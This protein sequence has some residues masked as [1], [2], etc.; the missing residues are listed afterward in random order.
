MTKTNRT[1]IASVQAQNFRRLTFA[2]VKLIPSTGLV[3]VT[4]NN[5][6]GKTSFLK[7]I[8]GGLGGDAEVDAGSL[9]EGTKKGGFILRTHDGRTIEKRI[10]EANPKGALTV[11]APDG[12]KHGQAK[13]NSWL[14][15]K[16]FDPMALFTLKADRL[17]DVLFSVGTDP[18][19]PTKLQKVREEHA[20]VY[21]E[22]TPIISRRRHLAT[23]TE[24]VG[25]R[26]ESVDTSA[27]MARLTALQAEEHAREEASRA[28]SIAHQE[29]ATA[30]GTVADSLKEIERIESLLHGAHAAL[31]ADQG[32]AKV[33]V[34]RAK[35]AKDNAN[36][37]RDPTEDMRV[38]QER[39][40]A[41][42]EIQAAIQPWSRWDEARQELEKLAED[43]DHLKGRLGQ[44]KQRE[45]D[46]LENAGIPVDGLSFGD[47]GEPLL[48]GKSL[49]LASGREKVDMAVAVAF[50][51]DPE[52]RVCLLDEE[53][54]GLDLEA[55]AHLHQR[56]IKEEFQIWLCRVG[57]ES[58][59][60]IIVEDGVA[61]DLSPELNV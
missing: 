55:M 9:H 51:A 16:S 11:T 18:D 37:L 36:T 56:A 25:D 22:R 6:A 48:N 4:G 44:L 2:E 39:L 49:S 53:A 33:A 50:A 19:L 15:H 52:I 32:A 10:T 14:G 35:L 8:A 41:A 5:L 38:V 57:I 61:S 12:G 58:P 29:V 40:Q 20:E 27:E 24:P 21:E 3:R 28:S 23:L 17:R 59:G 43:E 1:T 7:I 34:R 45:A 54:N 46:L 42:S 13:L 31:K 47:G 60:E 26:P 30:E